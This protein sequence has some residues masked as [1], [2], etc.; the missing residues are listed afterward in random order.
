MLQETIDLFAYYD[1]PRGDA[2]GGYLRCFR[3]EPMPEMSRTLLRPA[4]LVF[5]GGGYSALSQ[6]EEEPVAT[7]F[8]AAGYDAFTLKYDLAPACYPLQLQEAAMAVAYLHENAEKL[9]LLPDKIA[10]AG[11]SAGGHLLGCVFALWDDPAVRAVLGDRCAAARPDAAVF[12][13]PVVTSDPRV[14]HEGSFV[15]FCGGKVNADDYSIEKK[16]RRGCP[17]AFIWG[18]TPDDCVPAQNF[19][20]LYAACLEQGVP[21]ELHIFRDGWHGM[22]VCNEEVSGLPLPPACTYSQPWLPLCKTFLRT[23]DFAVRERA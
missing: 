12:G 20:R 1:F 16:V 18:N 5:P 23:L 2:K 21:A 9:C 6:R 15:N 14:W 11:F 19:V 13:Y 8:Y 10:A 22:S 4:M 17:P 3:H 7:E